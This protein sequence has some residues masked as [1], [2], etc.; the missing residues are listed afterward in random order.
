MLT[1]HRRG[2]GILRGSSWA[3]ARNL[4]HPYLS[5]LNDS[6]QTEHTTQPSPF[7]NSLRYYNFIVSKDTT[8][9]LSILFFAIQP[10]Q[11]PILYKERNSV[12]L[13]LIP[14][15]SIGSQSPPGFNQN[16]ISDT[17]QTRS[18]QQ[19]VWEPNVYKLLPKLR[20]NIYKYI[21]SPICQ[22]HPLF[23]FEKQELKKRQIT[24]KKNEKKKWMEV[25]T[26]PMN[27]CRLPLRFSLPR[28]ATRPTSLWQE[29]ATRTY[30]NTCHAFVSC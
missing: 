12:E 4:L 22:R 29:E 2:S 25:T 19:D 7:R 23:L 8:Y 16:R 11:H 30:A 5:R 28:C 27:R 26:P 17:P 21:L 6:V 24:Q 20:K 9:V 13:S 10:T 18:H 15:I 1:R 3:A 14:L